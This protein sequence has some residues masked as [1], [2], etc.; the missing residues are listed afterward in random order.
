MAKKIIIAAGGTG[1]HLFPGIAV[2]EAFMEKDPQNRVLFIGTGKPLEVSALS[3]AGFQHESLSVQGIRG[4]GLPNQIL[5]VLKLPGA[6]VKSL[7]MIRRFKPDLIIGIGSYVSGPVA[8]GAW[9]SGVRIALHEQ[10]VTPGMTN[11]A[12]SFLADRI[13]VSFKETAADSF[14]PGCAFRLFRTALK[15]KIRVTGNPIRKQIRNAPCVSKPDI[16][17]KDN[18]KSG[19]TVLVIGGSQGAH[20]INMAMKEAVTYLKKKEN[21]FFIHQTGVADEQEVGKA[22]WKQGISGIVRPFFHDMEQQYR[23]A[24]LVICRAGATTTAEVTA[25]GKAAIFIPYP[26]ASGNHQAA[27]AEILGAGGA[28]EMILQKDLSPGLLA[29]RIEYYAGHPESLKEMGLRA[30]TFSRPDAAQQIVADC[31][32]EVRGER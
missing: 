20:S 22:Y 30:K 12:L 21:F 13:Y 32:N 28:A 6:L 17:N 8:V 29:E 25:M 11:R 10:N 14:S 27:N 3:G 23:Q 26:F 18:L 24:D 15:K 1:G 2:A 5:S 19:M 31:Y 16:D 7:K 9:L 4:R